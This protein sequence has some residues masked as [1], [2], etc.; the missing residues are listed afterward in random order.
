[1]TD[2]RK[3]IEHLCEFIEDDAALI[4][5]LKKEP[6]DEV[7]AYL[8]DNGVDA[9][10]AV[11]DI[12]HAMHTGTAG[13]IL[14]SLGQMRY[15]LSQFATRPALSFSL[16][17]VIAIVGLQYLYPDSPP[18]VLERGPAPVI[19]DPSIDEA[20][21]ELEDLHARIMAL[22]QERRFA[23]AEPLVRQ[24][25]DSVKEIHGKDH[26][27][28]ANALNNLAVVEKRLGRYDQAGEHYRQALEIQRA[29]FGDTHPGTLTTMKNLGLLYEE[30]GRYRQAETVYQNIFETHKA[31]FGTNDTRT[32]ESRNNLI[33]FYQKFGNSF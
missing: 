32:I 17:M 10:E 13:A 6:I 29:H 27:D 14:A 18:P 11:A 8:S 7:H 30:T 12:R 31:E 23:E 20:A 26:P 24:V 3:E 19:V 1:M 28:T 21:E 22:Y 2:E 9:R 33:E 5:E 4:E 16:M 15:L 25:L